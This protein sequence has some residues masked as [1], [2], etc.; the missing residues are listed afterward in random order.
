MGF[1]LLV[2][3]QSRLVFC[4]NWSVSPRFIE[5]FQ[6]DLGSHC[7]MSKGHPHGGSILSKR[8]KMLERYSQWKK[9]DLLTTPP[10]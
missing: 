9:V 10:P 8:V 5:N 3:F 2:L 4:S 6:T 1:F 7:W